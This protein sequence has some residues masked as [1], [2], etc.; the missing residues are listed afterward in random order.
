MIINMSKIGFTGISEAAR[1][2]MAHY[3]EHYN[4]PEAFAALGKSPSVHVVTPKE[5]AL[6]SFEEY[7]DSAL[8]IVST[9]KDSFSKSLQIKGAAVK[10]PDV[11]LLLHLV[12]TIPPN[13]TE[14]ILEMA[15]DCVDIID[16]ELTAKERKA[17]REVAK[18][19]FNIVV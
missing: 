16:K 8:F 9:S 1:E 14:D 12:T 15:N 3:P 11:T 17:A 13:Y 18:R 7:G 5:V 4:K 2:T 19:E 10:T 6:N